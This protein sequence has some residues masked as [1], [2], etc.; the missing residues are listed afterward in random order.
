MNPNS[1]ETISQAVA[2]E[3]EAII[4][5]VESVDEGDYYTDEN[6]EERYVASVERTKAA[7]V[8]KIRARVDGATIP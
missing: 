7:I 2:A 8:A 1:Q 6:G 3:R 5:I 4:A